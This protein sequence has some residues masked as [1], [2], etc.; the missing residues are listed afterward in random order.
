MLKRRDLANGLLL[1]SVALMLAAGLSAQGQPDR[2]VAKQAERQVVAEA[3][4]DV[5]NAPAQA[6]LVS[7][8]VDFPPGAWTSLHTHG[9]QALNLVLEGEIT[10]R[11]RGA[12]RPH[13]AGQAWSDTSGQ[14]HS[15]GNTGTGRARLLTNFLLPKGAP[16]ITVIEETQFGPGVTS[17]A[18]FSLPRLAG[19][20]EILLQV[21]DLPPGWR[22]ERASPGYAAVIVMEG[23]VT[24]AAGAVAKSYR[25]GEAW[26]A[27]ADTVVTDRNP[28]AGRARIFATYLLPKGARP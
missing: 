13:T 27:A 23:E 9:G 8:V 5:T 2:E 10:L 18:R 1:P 26:S 19:D 25:V 4:F 28:S 3:R 20:T 14:V 24:H 15:A 17:E 11:Q 22:A 21:V 7:L 6:D 16:Q 12:D